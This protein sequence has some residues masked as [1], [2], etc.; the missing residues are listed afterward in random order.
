MA[1]VR[2]ILILVIMCLIAIFI[3]QNVSVVQIRFLSWDFFLSRALLVF[4][5]LVAGFIVGWFSGSMLCRNKSKSAKAE[6]K[7]E[8]RGENE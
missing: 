6:K 7:P 4:F 3:A 8:D 2:V 1:N 5:T